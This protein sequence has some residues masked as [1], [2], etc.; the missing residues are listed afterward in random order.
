M[1][2]TTSS[3]M[4]EGDK[5]GSDIFCLLQ[6]CFCRTN[7]NLNALSHDTAIMLVKR[8]IEQG[9]NVREVGVVLPNLPISLSSLKILFRGFGLNWDVQMCGTYCKGHY[10]DSVSF[11]SK[12]QRRYPF[13]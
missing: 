8:A 2:H 9:V 3:R 12:S 5:V 6:L 13:T 7:Y 10:F 11:P 1:T 4:S